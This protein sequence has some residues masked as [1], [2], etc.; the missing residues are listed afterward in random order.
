MMMSGIGGSSTI[1]VTTVKEFKIAGFPV[2]NVEFIVGGPDMGKAGLLGYNILRV[3]DVEY[4]LANG[5]IRIWRSKDCGGANLAYWANA[6]TSPVSVINIDEMSTGQPHILAQASVNGARIRVLFDTGATTSMLAVHAAARSG[7]YPDS[8]GAMKGGTAAGIGMQIRESWIAPFASF[9]IGDEEVTNTHLRIGQLV[10]PD[11]DMLLGADFFLSHRIY[12]ASR[13]NKLFFTYNGGHVFDL[14]VQQASASAPPGEANGT[15]SGQPHDAPGSA[16]PA[17]AQGFDRRG[18]AYVARQDFGHAIRDLT[19]AVELDPSQPEYFYDRAIA[20]LR[21][22][23]AAQAMGDLDQAIKLKPEDAQSLLLRAQIRLANKEQA[24][25]ITDLDAADRA[26]PKEASI[27]LAIGQTY[28]RADL[29]P[30]AIAQ[31][32]LWISAHKADAGKSQGLFMRC[33]ARALWGQGLDKALSDCNAAVALFPKP[34]GGPAL[35]TRGLVR[36]RRG[37][38]DKSVDDYSEALKVNPQSPWALYGRGLAK[39]RKGMTVAGQTDEAA[40]RHTAPHIED[41]FH[42]YG[43]VPR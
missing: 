15:E 21:N 11:S 14:S 25:A 39:I 42:Q 4:D 3:G 8:P 22:K 41:V 36:L 10:I 38:L 13:Q 23:Q 2:P 33:R 12:V 43:I 5:A 1:S 35:E 32:D 34:E 29:F 20:Y 40:A 27:R 6:D 16:E 30:Q 37:E 28:Q 24:T 7:I 26:L 9:K 31:F 19:R 17:D 18:D